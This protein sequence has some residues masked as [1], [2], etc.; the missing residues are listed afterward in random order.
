MV[1]ASSS[2]AGAPD[3]ALAGEHP[4]V[5]PLAAADVSRALPALIYV[6]H[7]DTLRDEAYAYAKKLKEAGVPA[8]LVV[9]ESLIHGFLLMTELCRA[10][11]EATE[12]VARDVGDALRGTLSGFP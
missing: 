1:F 3:R 12:R 7:F 4:D 8:R 10:S 5:S 9:F 2:R 6:A 11:N